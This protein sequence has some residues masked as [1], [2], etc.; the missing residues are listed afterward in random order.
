[1]NK[2]QIIVETIW[3]SLVYLAISL[4]PFFMLSLIQTES[5]TEYK[6]WEHTIDFVALL[7]ISIGYCLTVKEI[8]FRPLYKK[9]GKD[10]RAP[11]IKINI[12]R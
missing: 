4:I 3:R 1:M 5:I 12:I 11:L 9:L 10:Y 2:K 6:K 7:I 8:V